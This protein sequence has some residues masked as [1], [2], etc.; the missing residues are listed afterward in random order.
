MKIGNEDFRRIVLEEF[1]AMLRE[2]NL[3]E[4]LWDKLKR[5]VGFYG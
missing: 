5:A 4:G 2:G 3:E 1:D